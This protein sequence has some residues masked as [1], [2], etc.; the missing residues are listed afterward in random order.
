MRA[1]KNALGLGFMVPFALLV[2]S[3]L[4]LRIGN[5]RLKSKEA[6]II[7]L[8]EEQWW[9]ESDLTTSPMRVLSPKEY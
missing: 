6:A 2:I 5:I 1:S 3:T 9:V 8:V 7:R 4:K